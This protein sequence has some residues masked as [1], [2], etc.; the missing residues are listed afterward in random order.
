MPEHERKKALSIAGSDFIVIPVSLRKEK[1]QNGY[2][3][4]CRQHNI[5][6]LPEK[7]LPDMVFLP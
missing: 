7:N 2:V 3:K 1:H 5:L 6:G 4:R